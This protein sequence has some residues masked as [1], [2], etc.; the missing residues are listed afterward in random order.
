MTHGQTSP[1]IGALLYRWK[2]TRRESRPFDTPFEH[3]SPSTCLRSFVDVH[4]MG[5]ND[6]LMSRRCLL[7]TSNVRHSFEKCFALPRTCTQGVLAG[8]RTSADEIPSHQKAH[9]RQRCASTE[10]VANPSGRR[11]E[12]APAREERVDASYRSG[13]GGG[14]GSSGGGIRKYTPQARWL[15]DW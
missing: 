13:L 7:I 8:A 10:G 11:L 6:N 14:G 3:A 12:T 9:S 2:N 1:G 5:T 15:D 4:H